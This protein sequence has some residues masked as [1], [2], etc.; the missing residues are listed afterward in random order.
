MGLLGCILWHTPH[1]PPLPYV[2]IP[3]NC[4][5]LTAYRLLNLG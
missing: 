3:T 1:Y 2:R 5:I 4:V